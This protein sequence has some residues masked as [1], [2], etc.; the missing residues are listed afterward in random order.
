[1]PTDT[2][3]RILDSAELLFSSQGIANTSLRN[4]TDHAQVNLAAVN[5]HF[6]SKDALV[7]AVLFRRMNPINQR[8]FELLSALRDPTVEEILDA[9]YRPAVEAVLAGSEGRAVARL[10]GR[11]YSEPGDLLAG[12]VRALMAETFRLFAEAVQR[13]LPGV[14]PADV[15]LRLHFCVGILAHT[16][17]AMQLIEGMSRGRI[18]YDDPEAIL[19]QMIAF[20]A[21]GLRAE[22]G[23]TCAA[24]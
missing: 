11:L 23:A 6:Q 22:G 5:Y 12:Q 2:K 20:A 9:F 8:R 13:A 3:E 19:R 24:S 15:F 18:T 16:F 10:I 4:L 21:G 7:Q 1:M 14:P 17:G